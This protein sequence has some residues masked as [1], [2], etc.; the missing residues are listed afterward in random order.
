MRERTGSI[1]VTSVGRHRVRITNADGSRQTLGTFATREEAVRELGSTLKALEEE[2]ATDGMTLAVWGDR[3][4]KERE[5]R[6][7]VRDIRNDWSRWR[8]HIVT[9]PIVRLPLKSVKRKHVRAWLVRLRMR[10]VSRGVAL[11]A[12]NV[13][14]GMLKTAH[15]QELVRLNAAERIRPQKEKR[16]KE[17]WT[18][19]HPEEQGALVDAHDGP[20]RWIIQFAIGTGLRA[21]ELATLRL[22]DVHAGPNEPK[23]RVVVRYGSAPDLPTKT[24]KI[25]T[26]P[27]FGLGLEATRA[28]MGELDTFARRKR[29]ELTPEGQTITR[30]VG[31][32]KHGLLFPGKHGAF[33][34]ED[35]IL[36]WDAWQATKRR[37]GITRK[38][39]WHDLRHTCAS[40]LVSGWWG[41]RWSLTEVRDMLGH[42]SVTTT[43]RYAHLAGTALEAAAAETATNWTRDQETAEFS[44]PPRGSSFFVNR[45]SRVQISK[46]APAENK[47]VG[48]AES[49]TSRGQFL[50]VSTELL[51]A[52][53]S[54]REQA[55]ERLAKMLAESLLNDAWV[56]LAQDVLIGGPHATSAAIEL[57]SWV[58][59]ECGEE[60]GGTR[61]VA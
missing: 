27:L 61:G 10:G 45:R 48:V 4:L 35:H 26:V 8:N 37:A 52:A 33:R 59:D 1:D 31:T 7:E 5:L 44:D 46:A 50:A 12:R 57:A 20:E 29:R 15:D 24:G 14:S 58:L 11:N 41:R 32:N 19:L 13:L 18:Y 23:P 47:P 6:R 36:K 60:R 56:R 2:V 53:A 40:S 3:W 55:F 9:D 25:R 39:R 22:S 16:T 51:R 54:G 21:G 43:E 28:W 17:P 38:V 49:A 30:L 42:A 34:N